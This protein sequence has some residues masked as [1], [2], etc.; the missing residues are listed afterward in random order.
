MSSTYLTS[1]Y[2]F[3]TKIDLAHIAIDGIA[4]HQTQSPAQFSV[5]PPAMWEVM[6][7]VGHLWHATAIILLSNPL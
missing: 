3:E 1:V 2:K 4:S 5:V 7:L 6:V